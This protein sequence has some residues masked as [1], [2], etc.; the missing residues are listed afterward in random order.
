MCFCPQYN[1]L[2]KNSSQPSCSRTFRFFSENRATH[3]PYASTHLQSFI[4]PPPT[5]Q[6][7][8]ITLIKNFQ[9]GAGNRQHIHVY[10]YIAVYITRK[11]YGNN[12]CLYL[13]YFGVIHTRTHTHI[14]ICIYIKIQY[15]LVET[16]GSKVKIH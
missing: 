3:H 1:T 15:Q 2:Y 5:H 16:F 13:K 6:L 14:Y 12:F 9:P 7:H 11:E 8:Y 4:P 10:I